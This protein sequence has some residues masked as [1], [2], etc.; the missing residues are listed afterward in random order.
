MD[1]S[2]YIGPDYPHKSVVLEDGREVL[3]R[4]ICRADAALER[5]FLNALSPQTRRGRFL[6]QIA[7][8]SESLI[9]Q[10]VDIDYVNDVALA[11]ISD[12]RLVGVSRYSTGGDRTTCELAIV[13]RDDWQRAGLGK[14]LLQELVGIA[15]MRGLEEIHSFDSAEN[16]GMRVLCHQFGFSSEPVADDMTQT[17]F[18]LVL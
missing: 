8:P 3:I 11:A 16:T 9:D 17:R 2:R 15:R 5:E 13:V 12:N 14:A 18:S 4:P 1:P 6:A 7:E 10:L